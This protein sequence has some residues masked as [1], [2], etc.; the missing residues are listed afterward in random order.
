MQITDKYL[1]VILR[2]NLGIHAEISVH[3]KKHK[4]I[5]IFFKWEKRVINVYGTLI[6]CVCLKLNDLKS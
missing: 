3:S 5:F 6:C 4:N 2:K 1:S